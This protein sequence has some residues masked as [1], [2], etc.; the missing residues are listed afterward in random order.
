MPEQQISPNLLADRVRH[1]FRFSLLRPDDLVALDVECVEM[2]LVTEK[3]A[4][5]DLGSSESRTVLQVRPGRQSLLI[6]HFPPQH[7]GERA[8]YE[9]EDTD[10][11]LS[12]PKII[13]ERIGD[14]AQPRS[15][16]R[17]WRQI[18]GRLDARGHLSVM[19][20]AYA[21]YCNAPHRRKE[22]AEGASRRR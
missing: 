11:P 18:V 12:F 15:E 4:R 10:K 6:V 2:D 22:F 16:W 13:S 19:P 1:S 5:T 20:G 14:A 3:A 7:V 21:L 8:F 17:Q 9:V